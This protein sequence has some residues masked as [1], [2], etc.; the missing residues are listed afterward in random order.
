MNEEIMNNDVT[1]ENANQNDIPDAE[2]TSGRYS[3]GSGLAGLAVI[4]GTMFLTTFS[5][6]AGAGVG[7][8]LFLDTEKKAER[9]A[10]REARKI[11]RQAKKALKH[12]PH[13]DEEVSV[14]T[15]PVDE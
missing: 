11:K 4:A 5:A 9:K 2:P 3:M 1:M 13:I 6:M 10:R 14:E 12:K 15:E 8:D 7:W